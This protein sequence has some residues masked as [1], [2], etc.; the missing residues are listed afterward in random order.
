MK[1]DD[2][3]I[4]DKGSVEKSYANKWYFIDVEMVDALGINKTRKIE[5]K[6]KGTKT[7]PIEEAK[8]RT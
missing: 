7:T 5:E 4:Y 8:V 6:H 1:R 2:F 3:K